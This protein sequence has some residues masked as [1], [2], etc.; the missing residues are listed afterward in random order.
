[1]T[2]FVPGLMISFLLGA[3]A[4]GIFAIVLL[5]FK[6]PAPPPTKFRRKWDALPVVEVPPPWE[7]EEGVQYRFMGVGNEEV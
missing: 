2:Y 4:F 3:I 1:M 7:R 5:A 6:R